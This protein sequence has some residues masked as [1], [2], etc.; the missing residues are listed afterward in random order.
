LGT[1]ASISGNASAAPQPRSI[2]RLEI[3]R[4]MGGRGD[5]G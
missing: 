3:G 2:V 5:R 1:I 4:N